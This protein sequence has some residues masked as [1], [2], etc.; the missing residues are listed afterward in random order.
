ML[1]VYAL[2]LQVGPGFFS[3]MR[4]DG[5]KLLLPSLGV[6]LAGTALAIGASYACGI[7]IA[8]VSGILKNR[9]LAIDKKNAIHSPNE[10]MD[11]EVWEKGVVAVTEIY[12]NYNEKN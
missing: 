9:A 4:T 6:V 1:F 8:D 2:A 3:S 12:R 10:S 5:A 7:S 11:L